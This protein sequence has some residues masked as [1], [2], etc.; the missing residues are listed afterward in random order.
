[1]IIAIF[2]SQEAFRVVDMWY[3]SW[4]PAYVTQTFC[5]FT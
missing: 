5:V 1:M 4:K 3:R 2:E